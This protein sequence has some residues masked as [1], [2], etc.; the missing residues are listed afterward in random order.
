MIW[1]FLIDIAITVSDHFQQTELPAYSGALN[2][3]KHLPGIIRKTDIISTLKQSDEIMQ[4]KWKQVQ[5]KNSTLF[6]I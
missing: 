6:S 5:F 1:D 3:I 2:N 4:S